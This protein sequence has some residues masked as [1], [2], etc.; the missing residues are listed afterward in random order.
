[1]LFTLADHD[2]VA[3]ILQLPEEIY[4][5]ESNGRIYHSIDEVSDENKLIQLHFRSLG[6]KG[7]WH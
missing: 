3:K 6:G 1:M 7:G 2:I 5:L 4:F